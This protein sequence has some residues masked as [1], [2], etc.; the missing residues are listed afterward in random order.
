MKILKLRHERSYV[1]GCLNM[2]IW[3]PTTLRLDD[4]ILPEET[5][6]VAD[7]EAAMSIDRFQECDREKLTK[8]RGLSALFDGEPGTGKTLC[9]EILAAELGLTSIDQ[10]RKRGQQIYWRDGEEPHTYFS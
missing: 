8:G 4:L 10:C 5:G 1:L 6:Q 3:T 2:L 9:A 7:T